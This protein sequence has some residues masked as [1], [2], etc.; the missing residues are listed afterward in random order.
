MLSRAASSRDRWFADDVIDKAADTRGD[1][2]GVVALGDL[3]QEA[4]V[5]VRAAL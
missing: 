1:V 4:Q 5:R 3:G 2:A